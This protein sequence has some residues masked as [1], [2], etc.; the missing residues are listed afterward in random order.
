M[1]KR[2]RKRQTVIKHLSKKFSD[3]KVPV[4]YVNALQQK[5][6]KRGENR[7]AGRRNQDSD[8]LELSADED[9]ENVLEFVPDDDEIG[10]P[11]N[12]KLFAEFK[13]RF[14]GFDEFA[15]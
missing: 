11:E 5:A 7:K 14:A 4:P 1:K 6:V 12:M 2:H 8:S 13:A 10:N 3:G 9:L 15:V